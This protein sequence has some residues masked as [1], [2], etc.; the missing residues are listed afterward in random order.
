MSSLHCKRIESLKSNYFTI[1]TAIVAMYCKITETIV[2]MV[3]CRGERGAEGERV[4]F[5]M[6]LKCEGE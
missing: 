3:R 5:C 6:T 2:A 1:L 4:G